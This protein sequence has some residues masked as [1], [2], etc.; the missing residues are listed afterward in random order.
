M[1]ATAQIKRIIK[2]MST[3][4]PFARSRGIPLEKAEQ[5][6][7]RHIHRP[8]Q[9]RLL[10]QLGESSLSENAHLNLVPFTEE[11]LEWASRSNAI[12]TL[13]CPVSVNRFVRKFEQSISVCDEV[14]H[15]MGQM[16]GSIP[17]LP[18]WRLVMR[19]TNREAEDAAMA[20]CPTSLTNKR[21]ERAMVPSFR[22]FMSAMFA[23]WRING[24]PLCAGAGAR[25][26]RDAIVSREKIILRRVIVDGG[27]APN[28]LIQVKTAKPQAPI[29]F[30]IGFLP[31]SD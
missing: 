20:K 12:L 10:H 17:R 3:K 27:I 16:L 8:A 21:A 19:P 28:P 24:M 6:L 25:F 14:R 9:L 2:T 1:Q 23:D 7:G 4:S 30:A 15:S 5:I 29:P 11:E 31:I 13:S 26:T 18:E 22:L